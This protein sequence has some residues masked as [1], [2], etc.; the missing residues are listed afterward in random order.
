MESWKDITNYEGY[1]QI[2]NN[3]KIKSIRRVILGGR[4][5]K[6]TVNE[7]ILKNVITQCGYLK[8]TLRKN[9]IDKTFVVHRLVAEAFIPN[10]ENKPQVN[11]IDGNKTNNILNNLEW[12]DRFENMKHAFK[13]G[14]VDYKHLVNIYKIG[15]NTTKRQ[16]SKLDLCNNILQEYP[17]CKNAAE[18]CGISLPN[19]IEVLKGRRKT[20]GGFKW[21]YASLT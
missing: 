21:K 3:G 6:R 10:A 2:S 8:V 19:I 13:N 12:N 20:A 14:L 16:I 17:S 9:N 1:Y 7:R 5:G 18:Q 15:C 11:H 4:H